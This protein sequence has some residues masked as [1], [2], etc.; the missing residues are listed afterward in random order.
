[1]FSVS[2]EG[3]GGKNIQCIT[4]RNQD[5]PIATSKSWNLQNMDWWCSW[6]TWKYKLHL[7]PLQTCHFKITLTGHW[8]TEMLFKRLGK[9][10]HFLLCEKLI[11]KK[12]LCCKIHLRVC[13]T[14]WQHTVLQ[15]TKYTKINSCIQ[16]LSAVSNYLCQKWS[17]LSSGEFEFCKLYFIAYSAFLV[18]LCIMH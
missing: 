10:I 1:M 15:V 6:I 9:I 16:V 11:S 13:C 8:G 5:I 18:S 17:V 4:V 7:N 14:F 2:D 3:S 12:T